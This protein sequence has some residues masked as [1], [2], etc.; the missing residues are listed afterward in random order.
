MKTSFV[1]DQWNPQDWIL[2]RCPW[3]NGEGLWIQKED[4]IANYT[5]ENAAPEELCERGKYAADTFAS[6][7]LKKRFNC[8]V[9]ASATMSFDYK[10]APLMFIANEIDTSV[11]VPLL[12]E[13][14]EVVLY[15]EGI[16][17]WEHFKQNGKIAYNRKLFYCKNFSAKQKY[18][19]AV[20]VDPNEKSITVELG[21]SCFTVHAPLLDDGYYIGIMG[22]EGIN[23]FYDFEVTNY[24]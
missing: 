13:R 1:R 15:N 11:K 21:E 17:V 9:K 14:Y 5:P 16:N 7:I 23:R 22:C 3:G 12:G 10:M 8:P 20:A 24:E 18:Q 2:V 6:M 4:C 19:M